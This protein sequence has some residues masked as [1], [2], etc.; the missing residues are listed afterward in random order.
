M[1]S[2]IQPAHLNTHLHAQYQEAEAFPH[3]TLEHFINPEI[4]ENALRAFPD[5]TDAGWTHYMHYNEKKYGMRKR[6]AIPPTLLEVIDALNGPETIAYLEKLTGIKGLLSDPTLE[7]GGIHQIATGGYLNIHTDF[8]THPHHP[9]WRRRVN[10][11]LYMNQDWHEDYGGYLEFWDKHMT[12]CFEK[13]APQFN[14]AVIFNTDED[15]FHGHPDPLN[16]PQ[17]ITRKS[18]ALYY[19]TEEE[20]PYTSSTNYQARP[21]DGIKSLLIYL[22]KKAIAAYSSI[23]RIFKI[24]DDIADRI[25]KYFKK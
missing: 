21:E 22:D 16:T 25:L 15:S 14:T 19:F 5:I 17:G 2:I 1:E 24:N 8:T 6:E 4:A 13:I 9:R 11:L 12:H 7:G 10:L 20:N 23:K 3:I 18:I